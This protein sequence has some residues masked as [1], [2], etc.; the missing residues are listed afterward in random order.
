MIDQLEIDNFQKLFQNNTPLMDV[1]APVEYS[2]GSFP[3]VLNAPLM[4]DNERHL[5]GRRFKQS[6]Q[7]SA[8][9]LGHQ[10]VSG[11]TKN[12]RVNDWL[13]FIKQNPSGALY[14]FRG[15]L[16]SKVVQ[17]WIFDYSGIAYPR[18]KG[19]YKAMRRYLI[20]ESSRITNSK[21]FIVIGG[22]TG[23][24]KTLLLNKL[25]NSIDLEGL[26]NHRG[27][28]FGSNVSSQP[29][30]IDFENTLAI[31]LI[32]KQKNSIVLIEDEGNNIGT[33]YLTDSLKN[34]IHKSNIVVLTANLDER[35][36]LSLK[37]YVTE[38]LENYRSVDS[39]NG[40]ENYAN[41]WKNSLFKIQKRLGVVRYKALLKVLN[42]AIQKHQKSNDLSEYVPL[43]ESLLVDYYDPMY[44]YQINK[45]R[46]RIIF[47]GDSKAVFEYLE[48]TV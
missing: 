31:K 5:V 40:F 16:R 3:G 10:L 28:A 35:I 33:I 43:I 1:R 24:G 44:N 39:N 30:Q 29:T 32:N 17:E 46:H 9:E 26:A 11:K 34:K 19:G 21:N 18:V 48:T 13:G 37:T 15:G 20:E 25:P 23:C 42:N 7:L 47:Q 8:I 41:Y 27:S 4:N 36:K 22:Q 6:G 38:M 14:C 45:K 12:Q 2:R